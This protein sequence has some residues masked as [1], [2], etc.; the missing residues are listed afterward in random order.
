MANN[1]KHFLRPLLLLAAFVLWTWAVCVVDLQ[2]IGPRGTRVGFGTLNGWVHS[3]TGVHLWLYELTDWLGLVPIIVCAAF[4]ILGLVQWV[5]RRSLGRVDRDLL[6]L[7]GFYLAVI[8]A[9]AA[10][11]ILEVNYRPV[12]IEGRLEASYPSSTTMLVLC[13]MPTARMQL[14]GRLRSRRLCF[15]AKGA[16]YVF[17]AFM[18][19]ARL[20]S[21][22]HWFTDI[23]GGIL[24]SAGL[25]DMYRSALDFAD[26]R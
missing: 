11:E 15:W 23:V 9:F 16:I 6:V 26:P 4:G 21:G 20:L 22:V 8:L 25:T 5:G 3:L 10:F 2:P 19:L 7:G 14:S 12:L 13:V 17:T 18:V 1:K 24:L